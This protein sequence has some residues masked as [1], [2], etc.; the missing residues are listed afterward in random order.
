MTARRA[1]VGAI[2]IALALL[3]VGVATV[4]QSEP[5]VPSGGL[6]QATEDPPP[7]PLG[8]RQPPAAFEPPVAAP[9]GDC[10]EDSEPPSAHIRSDA[11]EVQVPAGSFFFQGEGCDVTAEG[12][13]V[14]GAPRP[15]PGTPPLAQLLVRG[16]EVVT[17]RLESPGL[18]APRV[19]AAWV[20]DEEASA[21]SRVPA[22]V[23][24]PPDRL[25]A[26]ITLPESL[27]RLS[28]LQVEVDHAA[29]EV[30]YDVW[31]SRAS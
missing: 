29:G 27:G 11:G 30:I 23:S 13:P 28:L 4:A 18:E 14:P 24:S 20:I 31:L 19:S 15:P 6:L 5:P 7:A 1:L 12:S 9:D 21:D 17:I 8:S 25:P 10:G 16:R 22:T 3:A 26:R 2:A